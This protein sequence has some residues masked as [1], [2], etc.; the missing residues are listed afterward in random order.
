MVMDALG[1][2]QDTSAFP[3]QPVYMKEDKGIKV[4]SPNAIS[5][6]TP[7]LSSIG[8]GKTGR[9]SIEKSANSSN[10]G[11]C[12]YGS[13]T[14]TRARLLKEKRESERK[15]AELENQRRI[16]D[17]MKRAE[18]REEDRRME[19]TQL[20]AMKKKREDSSRKPPNPAYSIS[21]EPSA[22]SKKIL[23]LPPFSS[24]LVAS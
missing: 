17:W 23:K 9:Q 11:G 1:L 12:S 6:P 16:T 8:A 20:A 2:P 7:M 19:K 3:A 22:Y 18:Q 4:V 10:K 24:G 13:S 14:S 21:F 15:K 5:K